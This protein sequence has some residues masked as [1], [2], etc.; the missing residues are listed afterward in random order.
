MADSDGGV[1]AG[2]TAYQTFRT[3]V[4]KADKNFAAV[5]DLPITT[6]VGG[7]S[8]Q[9]HYTYCYKKVFKA[10]T[11]LWRF[12]QEHRKELLESG[13]RRREI[14]EIA[15]RIGQLYYD[16]YRRTSESRFLVEA[17]VFYEAV[18]SRKY[19]GE[20]DSRLKKKIIS[21]SFRNQK[22]GKKEPDLGLRGK[23]LRFYARFVVIALLLQRMEVVRQLVDKF[24]ALL[25]DCKIS[26]PVIL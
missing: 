1:T 16:Q 6:Y 26:F 8:V 3:L 11:R 13:M 2:A 23:E 25:D 9:A 19:F 20:E 24:R 12:Q 18:W 15:S 10:Y 4:E 7:A 17:Y 5:H 21:G 22:A 14:G